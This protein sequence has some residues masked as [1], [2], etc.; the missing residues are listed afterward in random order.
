MISLPVPLET[1]TVPIGFIRTT[2]G[3]IGG[4]KIGFFRDD[5]KPLLKFTSSLFI[6][7]TLFHIKKVS[8]QHNG[9]VL[10]IE[11]I[12]SLEEAKKYKDCVVSVDEQL[13]EKHLVAN[14][15]LSETWIGFN[16][17][18]ISRQ[19]VG[20]VDHIIYTGSNDVLSVS[21]AD[22]KELLVPVTGDFIIKQDHK[23]KLLVIKI[24]EYV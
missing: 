20:S 22:H 12:I 4:L 3:L 10:L 5:Y 11:E 15:Y 2:H 13:I 6:D 14:K 1:S 8:W 24:P 16:V 19:A 21:T 23:N 17:F 9:A 18:D 7:R